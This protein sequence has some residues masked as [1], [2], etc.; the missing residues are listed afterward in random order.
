M[1]ERCERCERKGGTLVDMIEMQK[2]A[3]TRITA[4]HFVLGVL[5][6]IFDCLQGLQA[7]S[8]RVVSQHLEVIKVS[9][10]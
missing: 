5:A 1:K 2:N 6:V 9:S 7:G 8:A 4:P 10:C 3:A